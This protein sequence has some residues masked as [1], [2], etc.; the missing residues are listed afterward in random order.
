MC[1]PDTQYSYR[2]SQFWFHKISA[3]RHGDVVVVPTFVGCVLRWKLEVYVGTKEK[4][5]LS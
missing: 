5:I 3:L 2:A 1:L 4:I